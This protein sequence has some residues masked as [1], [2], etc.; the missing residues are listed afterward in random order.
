[1]P[2]PLDTHSFTVR[3][4]DCDFL[5]HMNIARYLDACSDAGFSIQAAWGLTQEDVLQGRRI[6]FVVV[7]ADSRFLREL[8]VRDEVRVR[9]ELLETGSKSARVVHRFRRGETEVFNATFTLILMDL[10][11]RCAVEIPD[12]LRVAIQTAHAD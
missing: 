4:S 6:A 11:A 12:D 1:M 7:H 9:S 8:R 10:Q 5:G 2:N 3:P